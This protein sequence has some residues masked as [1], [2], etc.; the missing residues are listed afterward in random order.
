MF[1]IV[2]FI[3]LKNFTNEQKKQIQP[4]LLIYFVL[5]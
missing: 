3:N 5:N 2:V 1:L 4:Y